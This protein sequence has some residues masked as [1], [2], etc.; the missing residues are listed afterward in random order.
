MRPCPCLPGPLPIAGDQ[1]RRPDM[2]PQETLMTTKIMIC[3]IAEQD[4]N[5]STADQE[6]VTMP[7]DVEKA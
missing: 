6:D 1:D 4:G 7:T 5:A 3:A 2:M